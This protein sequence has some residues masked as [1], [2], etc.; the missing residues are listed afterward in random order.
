MTETSKLLRQ[1]KEKRR[2][3]IIS[4]RNA[5]IGFLFC[6]VII[7]FVLVGFLVYKVFSLQKQVDVLRETNV[8]YN[9][10]GSF[11]NEGIQLFK[12]EENEVSYVEDEDNLAG[13]SD[14]LKVYLTFDD[15]PSEN[16]E[17]ILNILDE[18]GVKATFFV[19]GKTDDVSKERMK[20]IVEEG[21]CLAMHTYSHSYS[22]IYKSV[23]SFSDDVGKISDLIYEASGQR[24][25]LYRFPGGSGNGIAGDRIWDFIKYLDEENITYVDWN[26]ASNDATSPPLSKEAIVE[27]VMKDVVRYKT[28]IVLMHDSEGKETTVSALSELIKRLR[29]E[30]AILLPIT[31]D[32]NFI[33]QVTIEN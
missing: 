14:T 5:I 23:D 8:S 17:G 25:W 20:Q 3:R 2:S 4:I 21:H 26:V 9:N 24:P 30:D 19:Q 29:A 12:G 28:S 10:A 31:K 32:T 18:Y 6:W 16:T 15:G 27:N 13:L 33:K 7:S 22:D 11:E 1:R